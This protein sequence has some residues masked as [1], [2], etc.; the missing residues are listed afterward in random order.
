[1]IRYVTFNDNK[2]IDKESASQFDGSVPVFVADNVLS[3]YLNSPWLCWGEENS[4]GTYLLHVPE[5]APRPSYE[6]KIADFTNELATLKQ[7]D[8]DLSTQLDQAKTDLENANKKNQA[9]I[10]QIREIQAQNSIVTAQLASL[11]ADDQVK[12]EAL[13]SVS[14][15]V[16]Q[17]AQPVVS[18]VASQ[19][20][21]QVSVAPS[22]APVESSV[23]PKSVEASVAPS[24][25]VAQSEAPKSEVSSSEA[26]VSSSA[27]VKSESAEPAQSSSSEVHA[28]SAQSAQPVSAGPSINTTNG[29]SYTIK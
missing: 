16:A 23:A 28:E 29:I 27:E 3:T 24:S 1:M 5:D 8:T 10:A 9:L 4:D 22:Q 2:T 18:S 14:A 13:K 19:A 7:N 6:Q 17:S 11:S 12:S 26:P 20:P 15:T 21:V 25:A